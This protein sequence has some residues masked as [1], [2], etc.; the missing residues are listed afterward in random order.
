MFAS[1]G[2][3]RCATSS[4]SPLGILATGL[5]HTGPIFLCV[6]IFCVSETILPLIEMPVQRPIFPLITKFGYIITMRMRQLLLES[7]RLS[8]E[9]M[10]SASLRV[11][12]FSC[13]PARSIELLSTMAQWQRFLGGRHAIE[14]ADVGGMT[15]EL[16]QHCRW[17][18]R[19]T[20]PSKQAP[21]DLAV[22]TS[23]SCRL[24]I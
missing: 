19:A 13:E 6:A 15:I 24:A 23:A 9:I 1:V 4:H 18:L 11:R 22:R 21:E 10:Y 8:S 12:E 5:R 14:H 17:W 7:F 16:M 20:K 2:E 3:S